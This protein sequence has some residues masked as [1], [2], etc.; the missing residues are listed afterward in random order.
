MVQ[1]I[2]KKSNTQ[3]LAI[4][5]HVPNNHHHLPTRLLNTINSIKLEKIPPISTTINKESNKILE[6]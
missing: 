4:K 5:P 2:L 6:L 1:K 3:P